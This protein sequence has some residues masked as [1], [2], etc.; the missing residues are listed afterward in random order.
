MTDTQNCP[1]ALS[2]QSCFIASLLANLP[3]VL[4]IM[5]WM[6]VERTDFPSASFFTYATDSL[7]I[8]LY[9]IGGGLLLW[10]G[11][12]YFFRRRELP[13]GAAI[14]IGVLVEALV[15][16]TFVFTEAGEPSS[17]NTPEIAF[18][19]VVSQYFLIPAGVMG[20]LLVWFYARRLPDH[21]ARAEGMT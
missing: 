19:I 9:H 16:S 7:G 6:I 11:I 14:L 21:L 10:F 20:G 1:I 3:I 13:L 4:A 15:R 18:Y 12:L 5:I 2:W 8:G 17:W